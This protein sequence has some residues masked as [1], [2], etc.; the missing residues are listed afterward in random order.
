MLEEMKSKLSAIEIQL[1]NLR[2]YLDVDN[3]K[4]LIDDLTS[5]MANPGFWNDEENSGKIVKKLKSLK[6]AV[7]PWENAHRKYQELKELVDILKGQDKELIA[8]LTGNI[9]LL[10]GEVDKLEFRTLLGGEF[11]KSSAILSINSGAGGTESCDWASMLFRMY[12]RFAESH[13]YVINAT[14]VLSGEEAGIKNITAL[15]EGEYAYGYLKAERGVHRLVRISPF[16][17]NKRRHTS[18]ASVD[19]IPEIEEDVDLKIEE[20]DLRIDVFRSSG[21]G[22]QSVNTTDSA[23]RITH[24]PSGIVAQCQN[25]RSQY[26][27]KQTAMKILKARIYELQRRKKEEQLLKQY[28]GEKKRIEWGSQIRSYVMHPYSLVKDHRTDYETG[29]VNKIMDGGLD[30]FIEAYLKQQARNKQ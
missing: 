17:A 20:K 3:K 4:G 27:N 8:D 2:G 6:S 30:E 1:Q 7:E 5:Q 9:T 26:Q 22:G 23:V 10:T 15:I 24:L 19:V 13:G 28:A 14:D 12:S 16:D 18:F 11:D 21:A 25:E 29:D